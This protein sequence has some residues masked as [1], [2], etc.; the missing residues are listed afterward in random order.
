MRNRSSMP[1]WAIRYKTGDFPPYAYTADVIGLA[2]GRDDGMLRLLCIE[3]GGEP[4][5]GHMAMPGG[6]VEWK[7]DL[8]ARDAALREL[9]EETQV[10][11]P[12]FIEVLDTYDTNGRDPRQFA[13]YFDGQEF[14]PTGNRVVSK[15]DLALF[16]TLR[17]AKPMDGE[18]ARRAE[19]LE[20]FRFLP[21]EDLRFPAGRAA[22]EEVVA[23][24]LRHSR[25]N[26]WREA[27]LYAF[28]AT[29]GEWNE[30]RCGERFRLMFEAGLVEEARRDQWGYAPETAP[31]GRP[32][33][34]LAMAFDHRMML[35]DALGRLR[36]KIKYVPALLVGL[37]APR[38]TLAELQATIEAVSGRR[39]YRSNFYRLFVHQRQ[40]SPLIRPL[41]VKAGGGPGRPGELYA[42]AGDH[43]H[44]R[45]DPSIRMPWAAP[46]AP[47][48]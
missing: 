19:W 32:Y 20:V 35:A 40:H 39:V 8:T 5:A 12:D 42:W 21:W 11:V 9:Q 18:D 15:A 10:G 1:D 24:L 48:E 34:G 33:F 38:F 3:R 16:R 17:R 6:F 41:G 13:G 25:K 28:G 46:E 2:V 36:G 26:A 43:A 29:E 45:L 37:T 31:D 7:Q 27:V 14:V 23:S 30:E 44:T 4:F 47:E 22:R